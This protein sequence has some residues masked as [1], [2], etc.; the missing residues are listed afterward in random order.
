MRFRLLAL[1]LLAA[2][3]VTACRPTTDRAE[4]EVDAPPPSEIVDQGEEL[5]G[6]WVLIEQ[7]GSAPDRV[8]TVTFTTAGDYIVLSETRAQE[9][10]QYYL[11]GE[12]LVSIT[13]E[14]GTEVDQYEYNVTGNTLTLTIPGTEATTVFERR[15]D[16]LETREDLTPRV[17]VDPDPNQPRPEPGSPTQDLTFPRQDQPGD[18][19]QPAGQ[20]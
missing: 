15:E 2:L 11:S 12:N 3:L 13:D 1:P 16:L 5:I 18:Q 4:G 14:Q 19:N 10:Y 8:Y 20:N 9:R 7:A 17:P 6:T